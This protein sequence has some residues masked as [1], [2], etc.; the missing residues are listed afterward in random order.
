VIPASTTLQFHLPARDAPDPIELH[1]VV[2]VRM[3]GA[4]L[5]GFLLRAAMLVLR[6]AAVAALCCRFGL[7]WD[8]LR[9]AQVIIPSM[10]S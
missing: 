8:W 4:G 2:V 10:L 5:E 3:A 6:P 9:E 7:R 1:E